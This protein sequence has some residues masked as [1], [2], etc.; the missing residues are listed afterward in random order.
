[1]G[2]ITRR[3]FLAT[4][5]ASWGSPAL[6]S[7]DHGPDHAGGSA[8]ATPAATGTR[9]PVAAATAT[10]PPPAPITTTLA[11]LL[12]EAGITLTTEAGAAF[13]VEA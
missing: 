5:V 11:P 1:M 7:A 4:L 10:Q 2:T 12:T 13:T 9:A 3:A 8:T 6:V